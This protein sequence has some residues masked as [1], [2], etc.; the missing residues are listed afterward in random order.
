MTENAIQMRIIKKLRT[1]FPDWFV[2][3]M[4]GSVYQGFPDIL[5]LF[6]DTYATLEVK[7]C[8]GSE[9]QPNQVYYIEL[10]GSW[11]FSSFIWPDIEEEVLYELQQTLLSRR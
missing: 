6:E 2:F 11:V 10:F 1:A 7:Q 9:K 3:P 4:D 5:I 8:E